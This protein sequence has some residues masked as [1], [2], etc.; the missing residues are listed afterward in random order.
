MYPSHRIASHQSIIPCSTEAKCQEF[1]VPS[2]PAMGCPIDCTCPNQGWCEDGKDG[3]PKGCDKWEKDAFGKDKLGYCPQPNQ[4][5]V[6]GRRMRVKTGKFTPSRPIVSMLYAN[7]L[8]SARPI[9]HNSPH[10]L[11]YRY[12]TSHRNLLHR[13]RR[14][15]RK[16]RRR[17]A[18]RVGLSKWIR[19]VPTHHQNKLARFFVCLFVDSPKKRN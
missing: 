19:D 1:G 15:P 8:F 10:C 13:I 18:E 2:P 4:K 7:S 3:N 5:C 12:C 17:P 16:K 14:S 11:S 9:V 6:K